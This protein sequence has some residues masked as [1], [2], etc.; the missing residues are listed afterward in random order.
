MTVSELD[1]DVD[2]LCGSTSATYSPTNKR[3]NQNI[4]YRD[5]ARIIWESDGGWNFDDKNATTLPEATTTLVHNQNDYSLPS[6][7]LRVERIEVLDSDGNY[8]KLNPLDKQQVDT[9]LDEIYGGNA[10]LPLKYELVGESILLYPTPHS[11]HVT[12]T[13]GLKIYLNRDVTDLAVTAT[14]TQPGFASPFHRILSYAA[15]IDFTQDNQQREFWL[16]QKERLEQALRTFY[17]KRGQEIRTTI[18]PRQKRKWRNF[19]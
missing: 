14:T 18:K 17:S 7:A 9:G 16:M 11:A 6:T 19:T 10:G 1:S 4:A 5:V 2:F 8:R 15:A 3:R 12:E 13:A